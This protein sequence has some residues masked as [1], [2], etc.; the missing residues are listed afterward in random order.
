MLTKAD[1]LYHFFVSRHTIITPCSD[2]HLPHLF[3]MWLERRQS[4]PLWTNQHGSKHFPQQRS[5]P[6]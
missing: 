6:H 4:V 1:V 3:K 2:S 5:P